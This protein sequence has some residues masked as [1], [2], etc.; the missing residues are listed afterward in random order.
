M[1]WRIIFAFFSTLRWNVLQQHS[2]LFLAKMVLT[3]PGIG[4][5]N[6]GGAQNPGKTLFFLVKLKWS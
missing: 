3:P 6:P 4:H 2:S 5:L 1:K